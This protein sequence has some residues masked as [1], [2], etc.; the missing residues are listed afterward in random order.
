MEHAGDRHLL[1]RS[2]SRRAISD[3][4]S[5][6]QEGDGPAAA[7]GQRVDFGGAPAARAANS[8]AVLPPFPPGAEPCAFIAQEAI[9]TWAAGP[10]AL[11]RA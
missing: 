9:S 8:L 3:L 1:L 10:P 6:E 7:I 4:A 11:A 2:L 5:G